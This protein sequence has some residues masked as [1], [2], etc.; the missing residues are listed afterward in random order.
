MYFKEKENTNIDDEFKEINK[1]QKKDK[2][3]Q[4][5]K[6]IVPITIGIIAII[7]IVLFFITRKKYFLELD[8]SSEMTIYQGARYIEPGYNAYDNKQNTYN[9]QVIITGEVNSNEIG[10]YTINYKF[11]KNEVERI[12]NVIEKPAITTVIHLNGELEMTLN[13]GTVYTEPGYNAIDAID[14]DL[15][16]AVTIK[17]N[18]NT[19]KIGTYHI[20]YSVVN[21]SGVTTSKTRTVIVK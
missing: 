7:L 12:V 8:G 13:V 18:V 6:L 11:H 9:D 15:T 10:T 14:G 1:K 17:Q 2:Y 3:K 20:V 4:K 16:S 5:V 19:S 21:S